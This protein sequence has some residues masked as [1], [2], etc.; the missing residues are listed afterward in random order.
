MKQL[1]QSLAQRLLGFDRYLYL[2]SRFKVRT[3]GRDRIEGDVLALVEM[4]DDDAVVL[5][6]GANIGIMTVHMARKVRRGHVHSFEPV[7]ENFAVLERV[8][9][10]YGLTN[11][12]CHRMAL[13]DAEGTLEMVMPSHGKLRKQGLSHVVRGDEGEREE[14]TRYSVPQHRL[15]DLDLLAGVEV[16]GIKIDVENHEQFVFAGGRR[17]IQRCRPVVYTE[18]GEGENRAS[19]VR[20][21]E[22]LGYT[23]AV[24]EGSSVVPCDPLGHPKHNFFMLPEPSR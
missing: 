19:C 1:I 24:L 2:F 20:F 21:F 14:G 3:L 18:L 23:P 12:S 10:H 4:M 8:V 6:I 17:L 9:A 5:D 13:G 15:D 7:P 16:R 11:V 22:E